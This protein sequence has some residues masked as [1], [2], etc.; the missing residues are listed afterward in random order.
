VRNYHPTGCGLTFWFWFVKVFFI[1]LIGAGAAGIAIKSLRTKY[2]IPAAITVG[3]AIILWI[4]S[5]VFI[6]RT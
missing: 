2:F 4:I 6:C 3:V 5:E 1:L